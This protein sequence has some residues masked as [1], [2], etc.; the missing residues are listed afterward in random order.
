MA[1]S[2]FVA[3]NLETATGTVLQEFCVHFLSKHADAIKNYYTDTSL[4]TLFTSLF[5]VIQPITITFNVLSTILS[6]DKWTFETSE[7]FLERFLRLMT[8]TEMQTLKM[9]GIIMDLQHYLFPLLERYFDFIFKNGFVE[10]VYTKEFLF[11]NTDESELPEIEFWEPLCSLWSNEFIESVV[12]GARDARRLNL[13]HRSF[14]YEAF[15]YHFRNCLP[16]HENTAMTCYEFIKRIRKAAELCASSNSKMLF[17]FVNEDNKL[18]VLLDEVEQIYTGFSLR[19]LAYDLFGADRESSNCDITVS[20]H[21]SLRSSGLS[22]ESC[23]RWSV[24][25]ATGYLDDLFIAPRLEWPLNYVIS[26]GL[27]ESF[28]RCL[29]F[30]LQLIRASELLSKIRIEYTNVEKLG[31]NKR[32]FNL[33]L[34]VISQPLTIMAELFFTHVFLHLILLKTEGARKL[35]HEAIVKL[36][37]MSDEI[38]DRLRMDCMKPSDLENLL[39]VAIREKQLLVGIGKGMEG[40]FFMALQ[41]FLP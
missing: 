13:G 28:N 24:A 39:K 11:Y 6:E 34:C 26:S 14:K 8:F 35:I 15:S 10:P 2:R 18:N 30:L 21:N 20:F 5:E 36:W 33:L 9:Q 7:R 17:F 16:W 37:S 22:T 41:L 40:T 19:D 23:E 1:I 27:I 25:C 32:R 38:Y 29:R 12:N 3:K 31:L 4:Q